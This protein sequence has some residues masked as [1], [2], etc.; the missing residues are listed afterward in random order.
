MSLRQAANLYQYRG[1]VQ[2]AA[3]ASE[4]VAAYELRQHLRETEDG[5]PNYEA[6]QFIAEA[7]ELIEQSTGLALITQSWRLALDYWPGS[8]PEPWWDGVRDGSISDMMGGY[9]DVYLPRYPLQSITSV[10]VYDED[11]NS[12]AVTVANVFDVDTYG[13]PGRMTLQRGASWPVALR[14]NNAIEIIYAA[15]YG[16]GGDDVPAPLRGAVLRVAAY[17]YAHR[18]DGCSADEALGAAGSSLNAYRVARI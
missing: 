4:P 18:G 10:T 8:G 14:S 12:T 11:S 13:K 3:P 15:G 1:H 7:R 2:T 17:L 5:L 6:D 9:G 16:D